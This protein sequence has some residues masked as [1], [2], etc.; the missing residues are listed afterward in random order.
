MI[1]KTLNILFKKKPPYYLDTLDLKIIKQD[2]FFVYYVVGDNEIKLRKLPSS[3]Y[4][5][6]KQVFIDQ[7]Y[8]SPISY[9]EKNNIEIKTVIDAGANIGLTS[10][11]IKQYFPKVKIACIE[12]EKNNL[13]LLNQNLSHYIKD[14]SVQVFHSGLLGVSGLS[15]EIG[16]DFRGGNDWA[17]QVE[18]SEASTELKS[19]TIQDIQN[20]SNFETID[21]LKID[22]E[23]AEIFLL[24]PDTDLSFLEFTKVLAI[25]VHDEYNCR[26]GIYEIL[27]KYNYLILET[28]ETTLAI[29]KTYIN[30]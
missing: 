13:S 24:E 18:I 19:I 4:Y 8:Q 10:L 26:D 29:N 27:R 16:E 20:K 9:F 21:L 23:G 28:G 12:P 17:K 7:E 15:L 2:D 1:T 14:K 3:D 22:I 11:Y 6:F 5:V 25:E 30:G